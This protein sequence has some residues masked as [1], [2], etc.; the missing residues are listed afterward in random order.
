MFDLVFGT[1]TAL[2]QVATFVGALIFWGLG[3]LLVG[4]A[5]YWRRHAVRVQ[6]EVIGVRRNGNCLNA[7]YRYVSPS[8]E[9]LEATSLEGSSSVRG[10]ETGSMVPLWVIPEKPNEVQ[11]AGNHVFTVVGV[12]LLGAGVALFWVGV[13]AWRTGPMTWV[14]ASLAVAHLLQKARGIIAPKDKALPGS[15]WRELLA[16]MSAA[17]AQARDARPVQRLEE[18]TAL[19]E[20]RD[21]EIRQRTQ[22]RRLAPF[23]VLAGIGLLALGVHQSR[24]LLR[25]QSTGVRTPGIVTSLVSSSSGNDGVTYHPIVAYTD[26]HGRKVVFRDSVGTNPPMYRV[27][28]A[29]TVLYAPGDEARAV[30]DRG[31]WN[32]LP[33]VILYVLGAAVFAGGLAALRSRS[34][35][36]PLAAQS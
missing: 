32:W 29:V 27:G 18:L 7:V 26:G 13:T 16:Q 22:L 25:L 1:L 2:N 35:E 5:I 34:A 15:G 28:Q 31:L 12:L 21:K 17:R 8:G 36:V 3:G 30:L 23:L 14:V 19:P 20:Y 10:K 11:E 4:N 33:S 6:G 24:L 9:T